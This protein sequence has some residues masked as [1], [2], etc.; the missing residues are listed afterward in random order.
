MSSNSSRN[1]LGKLLF[2]NKNTNIFFSFKVVSE[3]KVTITFNDPVNK[4]GD[5]NKLI[6]S[7]SV[8]CEDKKDL[9][10]VLRK[11]GKFY[12]SVPNY[13]SQ[14]SPSQFWLLDTLND[15]LYCTNTETYFST[16]YNYISGSETKIEDLKRE[17]NGE[18]RILKNY[19]AV[20]EVVDLL[21]V[22]LL[23]LN[24][25]EKINSIASPYSITLKAYFSTCK[26]DLFKFDKD[27]NKFLCVRRQYDF[28]LIQDEDIVVY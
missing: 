25:T 10:K 16:F 26:E 24:N 28:N 14:F 17:Q 15:F 8:V 13:P 6:Y 22:D 11:V 20:K 1:P 12:K 21:K 19:K 4:I 3:N 7:V 9:G 2:L 18:L 23:S 5:R 27:L